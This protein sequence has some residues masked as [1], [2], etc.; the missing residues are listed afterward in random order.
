MGARED[1]QH[2]SNVQERS[3]AQREEDYSDERPSSSHASSSNE[4]AI[5]DGS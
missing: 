5:L 4:E 2:S 1:A 3:Q